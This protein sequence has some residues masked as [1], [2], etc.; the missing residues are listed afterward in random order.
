M[1]M[2]LQFYSRVEYRHIYYINQLKYQLPQIFFWEITDYCMKPP[3]KIR[4]FI[5]SWTANIV[6]ISRRGVKE[7]S[8][9]A[10][11]NHFFEIWMEIL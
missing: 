7:L 10:T 5:F 8:W 6:Y 3:E 9:L 2:L 11:F 1:V 4:I